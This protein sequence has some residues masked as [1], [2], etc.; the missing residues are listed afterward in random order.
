ML[1]RSTL[2]GEMAQ[3]ASDYG[4]IAELD[5]DLRSLHEDKARLE[6]AWLEAM[7]ALEA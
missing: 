7:E 2:H 4:R 1:F 3:H 6:A 5:A